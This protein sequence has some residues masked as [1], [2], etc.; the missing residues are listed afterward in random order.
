M[1]LG[2]SISPWCSGSGSICIVTPRPMPARIFYSPQKAPQ[3][4]AK[5]S[6][7]SGARTDCTSPLTGLE[8]GTQATKGMVDG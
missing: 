5:A 1:F 3:K 2:D 4:A 6:G 7:S 8:D